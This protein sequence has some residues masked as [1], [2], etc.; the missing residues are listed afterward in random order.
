MRYHHCFEETIINNVLCIF[1]VPGPFVRAA[2]ELSHSP[3]TVALADGAGPLRFLGMRR[4]CPG[5]TSS[6]FR[7]VGSPLKLLCH[8]NY[9]QSE[10]NVKFSMADKHMLFFK[11]KGCIFIT[12][13]KY[14]FHNFIILS[15]VYT[16]F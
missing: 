9:V 14:I 7:E 10:T 1:Y 4:G 3:L 11:E 16:S 12:I 5:H 2:H 6:V 13:R 15:L 8:F